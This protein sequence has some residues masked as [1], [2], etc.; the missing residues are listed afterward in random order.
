MII[1][2]YNYHLNV[3]GETVLQTKIMFIPSFI[4]TYIVTFIATFNFFM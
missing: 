4:F 2:L 3:I 1:V